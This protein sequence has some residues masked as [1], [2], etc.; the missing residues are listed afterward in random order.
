MP[1]SSPTL[2]DET[3]TFRLDRGLKAALTRAAAEDDI[4]PAELIRVLVRR[5]LA[6][7]ARQAFETE[8][9]RQ[10][11]VIAA[12]AAQADGDEAQVMRELDAHLQADDFADAWKARNAAIW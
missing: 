2:K 8:A 4:Q 6:S 10:S 5:H 11:L 1:R 9:H 3:F 12:N 7:Q